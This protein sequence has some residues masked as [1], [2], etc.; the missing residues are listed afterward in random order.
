VSGCGMF[1]K[2]KDCN[3]IVQA[4]H[5]AEK[6]LDDAT[7]HH[8][9]ED[10]VAELSSIAETVTKAKG[11][12]DGVEVKDET[13]VTGKKDLVTLYDDLAALMAA[14]AGSAGDLMKRVEGGDEAAAGEIVTLATDFETKVKELVAREHKLI[15]GLDAYCGAT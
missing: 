10:F 13:L 6:M 2:V 4:T 7:E 1:N 14:T 15:E 12:I 11:M 3:S 5:D 9:G 8:D